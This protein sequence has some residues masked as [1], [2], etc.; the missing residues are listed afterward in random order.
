MNEPIGDKNGSKSFW[1]TPIGIAVQAIIGASIIATSIQ[2][3]IPIRADA[4]TKA[5][6]DKLEENILHRIELSSDKVK[7]DILL[8]LFQNYYTKDEV[9][10]DKVRLPLQRI[11]KYIE[12]DEARYYKHEKILNELREKVN[13]IQIEHNVQALKDNELNR[14]NGDHV[15]K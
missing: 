7:N 3:I 14:G 1:R 15:S 11:E 12:Q 2:A 10:P 4:F 8:Y 5:M 13:R 9:P 6:G